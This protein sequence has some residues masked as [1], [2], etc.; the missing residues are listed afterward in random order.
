MPTRRMRG[1]T[2]IIDRLPFKYAILAPWSPLLQAII[3][4]WHSK[5]MEPSGRGAKSSRPTRRWK[6][7]DRPCNLLQVLFRCRVSVRW[8]PLLRVNDH[9]LALK[10]DGTV[11]AWGN[12]Y[13]GQLGVGSTT[14]HQLLLLFKCRVSVRWSPSLRVITI[15]W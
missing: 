13:V 2:N 3:I 7:S 5:A 8:S 6:Q 12:N 10:S 15:V 11:W 14:S 4:I 9:S 1:N